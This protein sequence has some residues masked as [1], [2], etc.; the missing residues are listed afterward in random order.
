MVYINIVMKVIGVLRETFPGEKRVSL[1]PHDA[2]VLRKHGFEVLVER[3]AGEMAGFADEEYEK[4][5]AR[6][7]EKGEVAGSSEIILNVRAGGANPEKWREQL[8][9]LQENQV[10]IGFL[11]PLWR[12]DLVLPLAEKGIISFALELI[13]RITK[14]QSMDALTS[15]GL[16]AGYR[17]VMLAAT[18]LSRLFPMMITAGG[19]IAPAKVFV[20]GAG[21]AG[22]E[23]MGISKRLGAVVTGYDIR[24]SAKEEVESVGAKFLDVHSIKNGDG[25]VQDFLKMEREAIARQVKESDVIITTAL[26]PS[27]RAPVIITEEMVETMKSGS[28]II[29]LAAE[30]GGNCEVTVPGAV[31]SKNGVTVAGPVNIA[32]DVPYHASQMLSRN[33]TNLLLHMHDERGEIKWDD[34]IVREMLLTKNGEL[35]NKKIKNLLGG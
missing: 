26:I 33:L 35:V 2:G 7:L 30:R 19:T 31:I 5:G 6:V 16:I 21:V 15:M 1:T 4:E 17:A 20:I 28:V 9:V 3:G 23:A 25:T 18:F 32:S 12:P 29:D 34:E 11:D 22:L 8:S 14:A 24:A 10:L 13:P 27:K